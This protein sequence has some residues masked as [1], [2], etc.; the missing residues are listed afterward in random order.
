MQSEPKDMLDNTA[1]VL[2]TNSTDMYKDAVLM[3]LAGLIQ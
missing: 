2:D 3:L 1:Y